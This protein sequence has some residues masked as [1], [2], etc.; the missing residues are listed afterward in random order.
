[1]MADDAGVYIFSF[2]PLRHDIF[3]CFFCVY[4]YHFSYSFGLILCPLMS[5]CPLLFIIFFSYW[6]LES[7]MVVATQTNVA[8]FSLTLPSFNFEVIFVVCA[9]RR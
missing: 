4:V 8:V 7:E 3:I 1:M 9:R 2:N 6:I 5:N